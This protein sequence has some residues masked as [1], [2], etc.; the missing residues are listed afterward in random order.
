MIDP[1][2]L[3]VERC[4]PSELRGGSPA[5]N[6]QAIRD[7]F[8]GADGGRRDAILL[9]AAG[10]IAAAGHAEDLRE[11]LEL[12]RDGRRLRRRSGAP[13]RAGE[14]HECG[15]GTR[16]PAP[17]SA[18][19]PRSSGARPRSATSAPTP[20]R[21]GSRATTRRAGAAAVSVLVDERF[22]GSWD[23]LRAARASV[24]RA[25]AREGLLLDARSTCARP[26]RRAP[27][28]CCCC[29]ATS[30]TSRCAALMTRGRRP[31]P[32]HA[33]RGARRRRAR[34]RGAARR[35]GDRRQRPRS[36]DVRDRP[37]T[38]SSRSSPRI[39]A[40]RIAIAESGI[41]TPRAGRRGRAR[42]RGRDPRRL[43]A[44]AGAR[45]GREA[46]RSCCA[47]ARQGLRPDP[48]G[49]RRRRGRGRRRPRR[50]RPRAGEP[51]RGEPSVLPVPDEL[52]AVAVWVGEAGTSGAPVDQVHEREEGRIRGR[53]RRAAPRGRAGRAPA[54]PALGGGRPR[55]LGSRGRGAGTR[56]ARGQARRRQ[57]RRGDP[58]A[59][60]PGPST[61][62]RGWSRHPGS[63]T[64][65]RCARTSR[66]PG[67]D[68][69]GTTAPTAAATCPRR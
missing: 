8:A 20:T 43:D 66:R 56:R 2:E 27:T 60:S 9:N 17:A 59:S 5:E 15:L 61:R 54:R 42:R 39:P 55:P 47:P 4:D 23:D 52:L 38:R 37:Q 1:L 41:R 7:V 63:R 44:D 24:G 51:A 68:R 26:R 53:E 14:V 18:R 48:R 32:R 67:R 62:P 58:R 6:A 28:P 21:R 57:R 31:R 64:R 49:G 45:P 65:R 46:A 29:C 16:S 35:A 33:R 22:G 19:S 11:G 34:A 12:A 10:A 30:T 36:R 3:G 25:A 69:H 50:L 13:R 40:D